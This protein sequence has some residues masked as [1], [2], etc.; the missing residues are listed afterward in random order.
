LRKSLIQII[1]KYLML[2]FLMRFSRIGA[3]TKRRMPS[4]KKACRPDCLL[5]AKIFDHITAPVKGGAASSLN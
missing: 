2:H 4:C 1:E 5:A 3:I